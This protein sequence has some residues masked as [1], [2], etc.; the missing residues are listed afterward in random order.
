MAYAPHINAVV[1]ELSTKKIEQGDH[2]THPNKRIVDESIDSCLKFKA[3][4]SQ[5]TSKNEPRSLNIRHVSL[6]A[7]IYAFP[8]KARSSRQ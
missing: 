3:D 4:G 8:Y 7:G 6:A 1:K 5:V 2:L